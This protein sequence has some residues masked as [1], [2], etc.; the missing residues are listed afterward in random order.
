MNNTINHSH[1]SILHDFHN[2]RIVLKYR[3]ITL[4][5]VKMQFYTNCMV[6]MN[7]ATSCDIIYNYNWCHRNLSIFLHNIH[8][9]HY[10]LIVFKKSGIHWARLAVS[11]DIFSSSFWCHSNFSTLRRKSYL[12]SWSSTPQPW[13]WWGQSPKSFLKC[14]AKSQVQHTDDV[15]LCET[16]WLAWH[17]SKLRIS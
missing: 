5:W 6:H 10:H 1:S 7:I 3:R 13:S 16:P 4:S 9:F 17:I 14:W 2:H 8:G 11:F 12:C 15:P